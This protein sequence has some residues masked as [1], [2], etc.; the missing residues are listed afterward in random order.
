[1]HLCGE[2]AFPY[3]GVGGLVSFGHAAYFGLGSYGA[4]LALKGARAGDAPRALSAASALGL[5]GG[6][7]FGW[8]CVRNPG[9]YAAML[10]LAFAQD[11]WSIAF[12]WTAVTGGD[13]GLLGDLA[14]SLG[15]QG[16]R[17]SS[18]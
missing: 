4:A 13:N 1:M 18:G 9:V 6:L 12:Q 16:R 7:A 14:E 8:F 10:T 5:V 3:F 17:I 11:L 2:P 15:L